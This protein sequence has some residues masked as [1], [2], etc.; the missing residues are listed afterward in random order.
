MARA[1]A[2]TK[3]GASRS[4]KA[5]PSRAK[6]GDNPYAGLPARAFWKSGVAQRTAYDLGDIYEKRFAIGPSDRIATAGSC[7]AQHISRRLSA[8][9][10]DYRD[11]EPRPPLLPA[12]SA[13]RFGYGVFSARYGNIYTAR[14]LRQTFERAHGLRAPEAPWEQG[15]RWYDPV[16]PAIEPDGFATAEELEASRR[17]HRRC[18]ETMFA[19]CDLFIFT[20]GLTE[21]WENVETGTVYPMCPG[22]VAGRFDPERHVFRNFGF[23][24][25][26]ED[27][28]WFVGALSEVNPGAR[29]LLTVSPVPLTATASGHHVLAA[30]SYSK[31]VLRAVAGAL[32]ERFEHIDYYPSFELAASHPVRAMHFEPNL[33]TIAEAGVEHILAPFF[34]AHEGAAPAAPDRPSAAGKQGQ[35]RA[36]DPVAVACEEMMLEQMAGLKA[37]AGP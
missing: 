7:F 12:K 23:T 35:A 3:T 34:A 25:V 33:R 13:R 1:K 30:T 5:K 36:K 9:G 8:R 32:Y 27:M 29:I 24:E 16:R 18:V 28:S 11:Y 19:D 14:Q 17:S 2:K 20:L 37:G 22:T 6:D 15:G 31:A 10:F 26:L 21:A 4:R